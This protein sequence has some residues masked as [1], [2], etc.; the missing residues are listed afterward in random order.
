MSP[1]PVITKV[2][3]SEQFQEL[4]EKNP[5]LIIIKFGASWCGPCKMI[6]Q[7]LY[8]SFAQ[9]PE[10]VQPILIDIDQCPDLYSFM[11]KMR[12]FKGVPALLCYYKE[13]ITPYPDDMV[14]GADIPQINMFFERCFYQ[15]RSML[16]S[17]S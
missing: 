1:L 9:M 6:E 13:N 8:T 4:V 15:A 5:G 14:I 12:I 7:T 17:P 2:S 11:S 16:S 3:N 10:N